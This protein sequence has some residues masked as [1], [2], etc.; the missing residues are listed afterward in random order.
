MSH[1][2]C[3]KCLRTVRVKADGRI[4]YH[5][6][7]HWQK[8]CEGF[9]Q[10]AAWTEERAIIAHG[11]NPRGECMCC[12][13]KVGEV[14]ECHQCN[15]EVYCDDERRAASVERSR[16]ERE[17]G[18]DACQCWGEGSCQTDFNPEDI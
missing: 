3:P 6:P 17:C 14:S 8:T 4:G 11:R 2:V 12:G 15:Y 13:S 1:T 5:V 9:N 16:A 10:P 7:D 18:C